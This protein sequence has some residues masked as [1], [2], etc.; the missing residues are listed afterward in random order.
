LRRL[1][2]ELT[3]EDL[4][5]GLAREVSPAGHRHPGSDHRRQATDEHDT[6][7]DAG[8]ADAGQ[9]AEG[10][11]E[12]VIDAVDDVPDA[13]DAASPVPLLVRQGGLAFVRAGTVD[14][15]LG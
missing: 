15:V 9:H 5:L 13:L 2:R 8:A 10:R 14:R 7:V 11:R 4:A 1:A 6:R 3:L 12:A